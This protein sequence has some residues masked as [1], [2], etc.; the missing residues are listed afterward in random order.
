MKKNTEV[1]CE[2]E[3]TGFIAVA[4]NG[5]EGVEH[6]ECGL[7]DQ[8]ARHLRKGHGWIASGELQR[9]RWF[10]DR[11]RLLTP[12]NISRRLR[13]LAADGVLEVQIRNRHA[14]YRL[15]Q[16]ELL[17]LPSEVTLHSLPRA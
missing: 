2:C 15:A 4:D 9:M 13:E 3:G 1:K 11:G 7:K 8:L 17:C 14:H 6:V 16:K 12:A 10:D 5:G